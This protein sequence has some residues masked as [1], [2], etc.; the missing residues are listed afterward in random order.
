MPEGAEAQFHVSIVNHELV[1]S[2]GAIALEGTACQTSRQIGYPRIAPTDRGPEFAFGS[3]AVYNASH[4]TG[5]CVMSERSFATNNQ[6]RRFMNRNT[7]RTL[8]LFGVPV[9]LS[10]GLASLGP[11]AAQEN[12]PP[13]T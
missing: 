12:P 5:A 4:V 3:P 8:S 2:K 7:R 9:I 13:P 6:R 11:A 1:L 10:F